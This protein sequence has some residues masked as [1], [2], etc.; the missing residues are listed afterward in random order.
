MHSYIRLGLCLQVLAVAFKGHRN[1][2]LGSLFLGP[3]AR[4]DLSPVLPLSFVSTD[5]PYFK[6]GHIRH[7]KTKFLVVNVQQLNGRDLTDFVALVDTGSGN[8]VF[9]VASCTD[10]GCLRD[11]NEL[12][13]DPDSPP[14]SEGDRFQIPLTSIKRVSQRAGVSASDP[15][16]A[17]EL[18]TSEIDYG[19]GRVSGSQ[20]VCSVCIGEGQN[21]QSKQRASS[22]SVFENDLDVYETLF[23]PESVTS[24][25]IQSVAC[26]GAASES[27]EPFQAMPFDGI[28][29]LGPQGLSLSGHG[30]FNE[31][32]T[33]F[34]ISIPDR[35][36]SDKD[37]KSGTNHLED[38]DV[39]SGIKHIEESSEF[40]SLGPIIASAKPSLQF[41]YGDNSASLSDQG[42]S[43]LWLPKT[44]NDLSSLYWSSIVSYAQ[45]GSIKMEL[46]GTKLTSGTTRFSNSVESSLY[47]VWDTGTVSWLTNPAGREAIAKIIKLS[48]KR[49][50]AKDQAGRRVKI[51]LFFHVD[52]TPSEQ[53]NERVTEDILNRAPEISNTESGFSIFDLLGLPRLTDMFSGNSEQQAADISVSITAPTD[54][55]K[56]QSVSLQGVPDT[57]PV[58]IIGLDAIRGSDMFYDRLKNR[59]GIVYTPQV[60]TEVLFIPAID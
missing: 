25:C 59:V 32:S 39:R 58:V 11:R 29:G 5:R 55:S 31:E 52:P 46:A 50:E 41:F 27:L 60:E 19:T 35:M 2:D 30:L 8:F 3:G 56:I 13:A 36:D 40:D 54:P 53:S 21:K 18:E 7:S 48:E 9:P 37:G 22:G 28:I 20:S 14:E 51:D 57:T 43:V 42:R 15:E 47:V 23:S 38:L 4:P 10:E 33:G 17:P 12:S 45:V 16:S 44:P 6:K 49:D 1:R 24:S 26:F 34:L